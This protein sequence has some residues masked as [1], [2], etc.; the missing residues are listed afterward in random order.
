MLLKNL[1][2]KLNKARILFTTKIMPRSKAELA[3]IIFTIA[4]KATLML[5]VIQ[6]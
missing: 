6:V 5:Q 3:M 4:N 2:E 1:V